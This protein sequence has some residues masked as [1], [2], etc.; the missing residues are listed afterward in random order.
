L[1]D[2]GQAL[3]LFAKQGEG[4]NIGAAHV[5]LAEAL[6]YLGEDREAWQHRGVALS[7]LPVTT[8]KRRRQNLLEVV[9]RAIEEEDP[10][11]A[12]HFREAAVA[13]ARRSGDPAALSFA[14]Q[15]RAVLR[16]QTG[17]DSGASRDLEAAKRLISE[18]SVEQRRSIKAEL[19]FAE[20]KVTLEE[21]PLTSALRYFSTPGN[22]VRQLEA[23]VFLARAE[24]KAGHTKQAEEDIAAGLDEA[25][26]MREHL[27]RG[28]LRSTYFNRMQ[29][30]F[31]LLIASA[32]EHGNAQAAFEQAERARARSLLDQFDSAGSGPC[33]APLT[34][35]ALQKCLPVGVA[36][37]EYAAPALV[38]E[39]L[40]VSGQ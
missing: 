15:R 3:R 35:D 23:R 22:R 4:E 21:K 25:E 24:R 33:A 36:I 2:Y 27:D 30:L 37:V 14:L 11:T 18:V 12:L 1:A 7:L 28:A 39:G 17:D 29:P 34:L 6:N 13:E 16:H 38:R 10:G 26:W 32:L 8:S 31:D 9:E 19:D 20:G 40:F 5:L